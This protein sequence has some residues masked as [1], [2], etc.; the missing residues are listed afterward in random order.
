V[1]VGDGC[2]IENSEV[3]DAILWAGVKVENQNVE[4]A[5]IHE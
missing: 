3:S 5:V 2:V 1:S 4:K